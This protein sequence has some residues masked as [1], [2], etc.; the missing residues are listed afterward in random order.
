MAGTTGSYEL[1]RIAIA[2]HWHCAEAALASSLGVLL[3]PQH[4]Q[5]TVGYLA[6]LALAAVCGGAAAASVAAKSTATAAA[7][8]R[9]EGGQA[10][11]GGVDGNGSDGSAAEKMTE[12]QEEEFLVTE[13]AELCTEV[14]ALRATVDAGRADLA[15]LEAAVARGRVQLEA[16]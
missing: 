16:N 5:K 2:L 6:F 4:R 1:G 8:Q 3:S 15:A 10:A 11:V 9:D 7:S 13:N 12:E 14:E